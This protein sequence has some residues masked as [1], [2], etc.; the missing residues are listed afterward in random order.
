MP[1]LL[2]GSHAIN[3]AMDV[4]PKTATAVEKVFKVNA[5]SEQ[6]QIYE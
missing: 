1:W 3:T 4:R 5:P 6:L 2:G